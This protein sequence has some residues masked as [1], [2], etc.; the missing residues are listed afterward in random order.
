MPFPSP[1][2]AKGSVRNTLSLSSGGHESEATNDLSRIMSKDSMAR[3]FNVV[4]A[5]LFHTKPNPRV[6]RNMIQT[7]TQSFG[8]NGPIKSEHP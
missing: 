2:G 4:F 5:M 8:A 6:S 3:L 7:S 1:P